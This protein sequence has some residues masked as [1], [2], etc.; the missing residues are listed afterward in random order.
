MSDG[1]DRSAASLCAAMW[2]VL[3]LLISYWGLSALA[4][5][6]WPLYLKS[7]SW[8]FVMVPETSPA[9]EFH[10]TWSPTENWGMVVLERGVYLMG[11]V[12]EG[13]AVVVSVESLGFEKME[14]DG[15]VIGA[16]K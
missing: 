5:R 11:R 1:V 16:C 9:S 13:V 8:I 6:V 15:M 7:L 14:G 12:M 3:S 10:E 2:S 4:R